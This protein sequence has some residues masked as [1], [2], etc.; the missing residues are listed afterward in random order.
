MAAASASTPVRTA[1]PSSAS[2]F[3]SVGPRSRQIPNTR[4]NVWGNIYE[5]A[6]HTLRSAVSLVRIRRTGARGAGGVPAGAHGT[7]QAGRLQGECAQSEHP[8]Q[9]YQRDGREREDADAGRLWR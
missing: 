5:T 2:S 8:A 1:A 9:R 4:L 3:R 7:R 6:D